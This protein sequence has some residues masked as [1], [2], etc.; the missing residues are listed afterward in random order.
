MPQQG[1]SIA[2][3]LEFH[4][5]RTARDRY[6]LDESLFSISG[7]VLFANFHAARVF[8]QKVNQRRDLVNFPEQAVRASQINAMGLIH[9]L[10]HQMFRSYR[11]QHNPHLL[12]EALAWL[13]QQL[14]A[15]ALDAA[16]IRFTDEFPPVAVY[17]RELTVAEYLAG[18]T[19]SIPNRQ[20]ALEELLLLWLT[21]ANPAFSPFME[22]FDD[23]ALEKETAY[24]QI[25]STLYAFFG[26][27]PAAGDDGRQPGGGDGRQPGDGDGRQPGGA[28]GQMLFTGQNLLDFLLA[29][30]RTAP[31]SLE[32]QLEFI[33]E[34][35]GL[36][37]GRQVYRLLSGLDLIKEEQKP[38]FFGP[39]PTEV[40]VYEFAGL[41][42]EPER[43]SPDRD[44]MPRLVMIA[45]N[46]YVWLDQ[47]SKK[48]GRPIASLDQIPDE[49]LDALAR[50][51][52]SGLWLIGLWERSTA[53]QRIKQLCGN[54]DA[55]ASAYS[56]FD[57]QIAAKL[58]GEAACQELRE[59]AW[60][61]G[62]RLAS[63]MVPNHVGID[64]R[65]V[66]EHPDWFISL[67]TQPLPGV[68]LQ[69]AEPVLGPARRPLYRGSLLRPQ[70]RGGGV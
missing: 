36:V 62:I 57:Y 56:L 20:V 14:G 40:P 25:I 64:G 37:L 70:R 50:W 42:V 23:T 12:Q 5:S 58:G 13:E 41:E 39:G 60:Q 10:T 8:A 69:R 45:K 15:P 29:P 19:T 65:W 54:A 53:S 27:Q 7:R 28:P 2:L 48:Y 24:P 66:I 32:G 46:A 3:E 49:E 59:R 67:R 44:W 16:L 63:D 9:E 68:H 17:R 51:G 6:Q 34:R 26:A 18:T 11:E 35:W 47:L 43:F 30:A 1:R 31:H 21:N 4:V 38:V 52:I 22:L 55:V 33:R 61:R